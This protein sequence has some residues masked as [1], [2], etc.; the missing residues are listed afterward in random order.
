MARQPSGQVVEDPRR[1]GEALPEELNAANNEASTLISVIRGGISVLI[2][3]RPRAF[4]ARFI[5][6]VLRSD[7][8]ISP[9]IVWMGG[10]GPLDRSAGD[11]F[12]F[13]RKKYDV[14]I[15]GDVT[16][17]QIQ[18][19]NPQGVEEIEK[20]I[21][22]GGAGLVMIGG[23]STFGNGDWAG[24]E[25]EPALPVDL[26]VKGQEERPVQMKPTDAGLRLYGYVLGLANGQKEAEQA[27]WKQLPPLEGIARIKAREGPLIN[28]L[29]ESL[30]GDPVLVAQNYGK[31][32]VLAFAGDSTWRWV[33]NPDSQA[34][35]SRFWRQMVVWLARQELAGGNVWVR[36]DVRDI[37]LGAELGFSVGVRGK[38][39]IDLP[40]GVYEVDVQAPGKQP[41]RVRVARS[42]SEDRGLFKPDE[43]GEYVIKV[44]GKARDPV[45]G[46]VNDSAEARF[47]VHEDD[48]EMAEWSADKTLMDKLAKEGRGRAVTAAKLPDLLRD[49]LAPASLDGKTRLIPWPDW[50]T[51]DPSGFLVVFFLIFVLC[52]ST[53]WVLRRRW[54]MA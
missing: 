27:A 6:E 18:Q 37:P 48:V 9:H 30:S 20:L 54:G 33:R 36:P 35:H 2:V 51:S 28:V 1:P 15:L 50:G 53:E 49:L 8:R 47:L 23:Y 46:E 3:D 52:L 39:G 45:G 21:N 7:P 40:D 24:T 38:G 17:R 31:G 34:K 5:Y 41:R 29:A 19:V 43:A 32:R 25:L 13:A 12:Q 26:N 10:K 44:K 14:I 16:A 22:K 42:G 4:E 11:L